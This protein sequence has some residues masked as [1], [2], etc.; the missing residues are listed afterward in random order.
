MDVRGTPSA[1]AKRISAENE[2]RHT[3]RCASEA[4]EKLSF[5]E[6][7]LARNHAFGANLEENRVLR[8]HFSSL[9]KFRDTQG[10]IAVLSRHGLD[11]MLPEFMNLQSKFD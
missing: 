9:Y 2:M 4:V 10:E 8:T 3:E 6:Q 7:P 11:Y 1:P 5:S